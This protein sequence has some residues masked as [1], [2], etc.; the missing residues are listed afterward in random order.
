VSHAYLHLMPD[1]TVTFLILAVQNRARIWAKQK[2]IQTAGGCGTLF[3]QN[4]GAED[5]AANFGVVRSAHSA[6]LPGVS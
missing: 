3:A 4:A 6:S 1:T 5:F 2:R